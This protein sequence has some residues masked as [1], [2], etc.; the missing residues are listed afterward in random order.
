M[1]KH[2]KDVCTCGIC[3][4][5]FENPMYLKCGYVCCLLCIGSLQKDPHGEGILCPS[6]SVASKKKDIKTAFLLGRVA[7]KVKELEPQLQDVLQMNPRMKKFQVDMT[8][9]MDTANNYLVISNDLRSVHCG[10]VKQDRKECAE[11]FNQSICILGSPRFTSG[12]HYWEVDVGRSKEWDVG[13]C[14]E[15][16][17]RQGA[18]VLAADNGFWTVGLRDGELFAA[19]TTPMTPLCVNPGLRRLG[20]FLDVEVGNISFCDIR[21]GTHIFTFTDIS[22][23]ESLRPFFTPAND[24]KQDPLTICPVMNPGIFHPPASPGP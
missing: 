11:R 20:V 13:V 4:K 21:D 24:P 6:C 3:L 16:A 15:S 19:S 18:I 5:Y 23:E 9:D 12:R 2:F 1:A 10:H 17:N 7:S 22:S 8:F 14:R